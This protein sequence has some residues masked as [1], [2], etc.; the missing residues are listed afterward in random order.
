M[1]ET[2]RPGSPAADLTAS[3][4]ELGF[5]SYEARCY[6]GLVG[7]EP[8]TGYGVSKRTGVPQPKVYEAL[9]KLVSRGAAFEVASDP[10]L[11]VGL[12]PAQLLD[13]MADR[14]KSTYRNAQHAAEKLAVDSDASTVAALFELRSTAAVIAAARSAVSHAERRVYV[15]SSPE[16]LETLMPALQSKRGAGVDIVVIDFS[17]GGVDADGMRVFPHSSTENSLYRHHQARHVA[18]VVDSRETVHAIAADGSS[19]NGVHTSNEAVIAAVKGMIKHD[20]DLQQIYADFG[21]MLVE[22]YGPG[23]Q[24]L[25]E[26]R[27]DV[28]RPANASVKARPAPPSSSSA[29]G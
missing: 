24:A 20:I 4:Q 5:S 9:R 10:A 8:Q 23:L 19:W 3:L 6:V 11:F 1:T 27:M 22:K 26:Y 7:L 25:E 21:P 13:Q 29:A 2:P 16:E 12:P 17:R 28:A 14:F 15:S 18:L